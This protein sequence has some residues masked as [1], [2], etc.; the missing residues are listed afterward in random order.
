MD[1]VTILIADDHQIV[2]VGLR[3]MLEV[4]PG[5]CVVGEAKDGLEAVKLAEQLQPDVLVLDLMMP[6]LSGREVVKQVRRCAPNTRII[7]LTMYSGEAYVV[8]VLSCGVMGYVLKQSSSSDVLQAVYQVMAG[9]RYLS[10]SLSERAIDAYI[11]YMQNGGD[12]E[13]ELYETLT[14]RE[15]DVLYLAA[16]GYNNAQIATNLGISHR[17]VEGYR[18]SMMRKLGLSSAVDLVHYAIEIGIL[19]F[20]QKN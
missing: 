9:Q 16:Q 18:A 11:Q 19:Q 10:P 4:E 13:I 7:V 14:P 6:H 8:E 2:R 20:G 12:K 3:S 1:R 5:F 15:Q 17:T